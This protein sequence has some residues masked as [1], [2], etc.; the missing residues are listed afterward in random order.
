[1]TQYTARLT[2]PEEA[3]CYSHI[4]RAAFRERFVDTKLCRILE[5]NRISY[6][7]QFHYGVPQI[8]M[9]VD[10]ER[11]CL[12]K[13]ATPPEASFIKVDIPAAAQG[14]EP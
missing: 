6:Y 14:V 10:D 12:L 11:F 13:L 7:T 5:T 1:M 2:L 8:V 4:T 3:K 9:K